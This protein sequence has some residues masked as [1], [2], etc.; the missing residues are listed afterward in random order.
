M[1]YQH[2]VLALLSALSVITYLDR[3]C[4]GVAGPRM[5]DALHISPE[6]WGWVTSVFFISYSAFEIPTGALGDRIGPRKVLTRIV[7]WWSAFTS[8]TGAV[9]SYP[10]LLLARFCFGI[11]EA[12]AYPNVAVVIGRWMPQK[13]RARAWGTVWMTSQIG[14]AMSPLLV[15]P[16]QAHYG[17]RASFFVFGFLGI[18]WG[19]VWFWWFRDQPAEMPGV[20]KSERL[21]ISEGEPPH[22]HAGTPWALLLRSRGLWQIT[23]IMCCY[24]YSLSFFQSWLQT[25]LVR[26]RGFSEHAL[27]WSSLTYVVGAVA[28]I[29]GGF[30]SDLMVHRFGLRNGRRMVGITGLTFSALFFAATIL[31]KDT[32]LSLVFLSLAY[33]GMLFQ[34][35]SAC[36]ICLDI[37]RKY[38]GAVFGFAN[39]TGNGAAA[40]SSVVFGYLVTRFGSYDVPLI[41]MTAM[42]A[43]GAVLWFGMDASKVIDSG[44]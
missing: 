20:S 42:L 18:I 41:P 25:Y 38:A 40:L 32:T 7:L 6:A 13:R 28:N 37:G 1:K 34:Q 43:L 10:L 2:R 3:V 33:G 21:E 24:V 8:L 11:G 27:I 15:V 44:A 31:T 35:P 17:W 29:L 16:L 36:V 23:A 19:S 14:A 26:G 39:M 5:Q 4:I 9:T 30:T 12:G 22:A